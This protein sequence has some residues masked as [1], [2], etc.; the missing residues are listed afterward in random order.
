[1]STA[2]RLAY[3]KIL[4]GSPQWQVRHH[5]RG[6]LV[7]YRLDPWWLTDLG[8]GLGSVFQVGLKCVSREP[9]KNGS[10][11]RVEHGMENADRKMNLEEWLC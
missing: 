11:D 5:L 10:C 9:F 3:P 6:A 4:P 7:R 8:A 2:G 1:M